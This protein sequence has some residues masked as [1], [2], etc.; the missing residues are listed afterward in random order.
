MS[1]VVNAPGSTGATAVTT[2]DHG[3]TTST[4][5]AEP[6]AAELVTRLT[7]QSTELIRSELKLAQAEMTAKAKHAGIGAGLFG[8]AG[9]IALYAVG[10]LVAT[11]ILALVALGLAPW[12]SALIVTVVLF[13]IAG[14]VALV[15]KK[16][17]SQATPAAPEQT[18][19]SVKH[20][21]DTIKEARR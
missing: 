17:V 14:V 21:V 2:A 19:D 13:A 3:T 20:D 9:V 15:G 1:D 8:G 10:A 5:H 16:Q 18:I 11:I 6:S 12:L 7:Q 4:G